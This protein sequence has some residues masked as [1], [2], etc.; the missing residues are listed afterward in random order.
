MENRMLLSFVAVS[1]ALLLSP[2]YAYTTYIHA[3]AV[4][5]AQ[6]IGVIT[7]ISLNVTPGN[8]AVSIKGPAIVGQDTLTSAQTAAAAASAYTGLNQMNYNFTYQIDGGSSN[9]SGPSA[10][11]A[12]TLLAIDGLRQ[13]NLY[14][15]FTVTGTIS[16]NGA[17]GEVGGVYDKIKAAKSS[18]I[19]NYVL[20]PVAQQISSTDPTY[21]S[22]YMAQQKFGLPII[23]V[24]NV[25]QALQYS[26]I[27]PAGKVAPFSFNITRNYYLKSMPAANVSCANCNMSYFRAFEN[28]TFNFTRGTVNQIG[29]S[30]S[31]SQSNINTNLAN[32]QKIAARGYLYQAA[33]LAFLQYPNDFV[34]ANANKLNKSQAGSIISNISTY[35][36][37]LTPPQLTSSNYEYVIGGEIRQGWAEQTIAEA[38]SLLNSSQITDDVIQSLYTAAPAYAWCSAVNELYGIGSKIGGTPVTFS[39]NAKTQALNAINSASSR[40]SSIYLVGAQMAYNK[41]QYGAALYDAAYATSFGLPLPSGNSTQVASI[42]E[43]NAANT[44]FGVWPS[45]FENSALFYLYEAGVRGMD[46]TNVSAAYATS[47]LAINLDKANQMLTQS[48]M[49]APVNSSV[50]ASIASTLLNQTA[51]IQGLQ[52]QVTELFGLVFA[53]FVIVVIVA[54]VLLVAVVRAMAG[55]KTEKRRTRRNS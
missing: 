37:D 34:L 23:E 36:S 15:N 25:S 18:G 19:I 54:V 39:S 21:V 42:V 22:Y 47:E 46:N 3:P 11:L 43:A 10:G 29:G 14:N 27:Y 41:S 35:C 9:V 6:N 53:L 7:T 48:F 8:G 31:G 20:V 52:S 4:E 44:T 51:E 30:L 28:F 16:Q 50:P 45:Q 12:F 13:Q 24:S 55:T 2:A 26:S 32:Y 17:V 1:L 38:N 40:G 49:E 5:T 33:D